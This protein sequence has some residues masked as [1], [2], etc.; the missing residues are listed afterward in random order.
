MP[1]LLVNTNS[2]MALGKLTFDSSESLNLM[3][4]GAGNFILPIPDMFGFCACASVVE[5][6]ISVLA[7]AGIGSAIPGSTRPHPPTSKPINSIELI[8]N[9]LNFVRMTG[10]S[11]GRWQE[12]E[13]EAV[14][15]RWIRVDIYPYK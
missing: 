1:S 5:L 11:T 12:S 9:G 15:G 13:T 7:V 4:L 10:L 6:V 3:S 8:N 2:L 14:N